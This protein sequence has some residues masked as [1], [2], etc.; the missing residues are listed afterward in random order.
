MVK[1]ETKL[2]FFYAVLSNIFGGLQPVI[3]NLRPASL[4]S[5]IF[6]GMTAL[7]QVLIFIPIFFLEKSINKI[8][9]NIKRSAIKNNTKKLHFGNSKWYL[10]V[11]IGF[12]FSIVIFLYYTGLRYAG[13]INGTL[14]LKST[15]FFGLIFGYLILKENVSKIQ[16]FFS[17]ILFFGIIIAITQMQFYLLEINFGVILILICSSI[18]MFGHT[19]SK[20]YLENRITFSSELVMWRNIFTTLILLLFYFFYYGIEKFSIILDPNNVIFYVLGG[21]LYGLNVFSWYQI[22]KYLDISI[23]TILITPQIIITAF[24]A[25]IL[26]GEIFTIYHLIGLIIIITCIIFINWDS[27]KNNK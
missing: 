7:I 1:K 12:M 20:P 5:L 10:F 16:I 11:L 24:F 18:W 8:N 3:A 26:L 19:C 17:I 14:A 15:A 2:G 25:S 4:D 9:R 21:I 27:K 6:S 22:I 13:S 23:G